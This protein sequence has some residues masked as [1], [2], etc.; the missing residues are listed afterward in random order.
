MKPKL[1]IDNGGRIECDTHAPPRGC[2]TWHMSQW[3]PMRVDER[4]EFQMEIG[5][6]PECETCCAIARNAPKAIS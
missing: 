6:A 2:D 5:R 1:L 4:A 3:R